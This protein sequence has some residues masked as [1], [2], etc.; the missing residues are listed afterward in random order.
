MLSRKAKYALKALRLIA[1]AG[2][3]RSQRAEDLAAAEGIPR[4]FL[5]QALAQLRRH[6]VLTSR[7]GPGGGYL[8]ARPAAEIPL[9][10]IVRLLDGPLAPLPCA[11]ETAYRPCDECE[12]IEACGIRIVM[13]RVRDAT[14]A[15][16]D[17]T[18]LEEFAYL[19]GKV[20]H[21]P[22]PKPGQKRGR[23]P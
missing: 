21:K 8:L 11:S 12:D 3:G 14:A 9:G 16:L 1:L 5:E 23:K 6:G 7:T 17:G 4:K 2:E 15:I 22:G 19:P 13:R 10:K 18:S 20:R